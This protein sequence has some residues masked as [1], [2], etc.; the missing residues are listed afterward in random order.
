MYSIHMQTSKVNEFIWF[1]NVGLSGYDGVRR[2]LGVVKTLRT[3]L[4]E[5]KHVDVSF[6]ISSLALAYMVSHF[7]D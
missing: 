6:L 7:H 4:I 1:F 3:L 2:R 5:N